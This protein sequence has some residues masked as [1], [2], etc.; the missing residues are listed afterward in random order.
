[1]GKLCC[2]ITTN[3][4]SSNSTIVT[5]F[6]FFI[7]FIENGGLSIVFGPAILKSSILLLFTITPRLSS[8]CPSSLHIKPSTIKFN[9]QSFEVYH[10]QL[11]Q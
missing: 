11:V 1:M 10:V 3:N 6:K 8:A 5:T 7:S 2:M 4:K 9:K